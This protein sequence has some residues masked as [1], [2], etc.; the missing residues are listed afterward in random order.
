MSHPRACEEDRPIRERAM[1]RGERIRVLRTTLGRGKALPSTMDPDLALG[2]AEF[3]ALADMVS[4]VSA[5]AGDVI[6][7]EG[8]PGDAL[9]IVA[10]GR[11]RIV[12]FTQAGESIPVTEL[13]SGA[14]VGELA[15]LEGSQRSATVEAETDTELLRLDRAPLKSF[16]SQ[17]NPLAYKLLFALTLHVSARV[18]QKDVQQLEARAEALSRSWSRNGQRS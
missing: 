7:R 17:N 5:K 10:S 1:D 12:R 9:Y 3:E 4:V 11:L 14:I 13:E 8:D 18:R 16:L 2:E 15:L 6:M